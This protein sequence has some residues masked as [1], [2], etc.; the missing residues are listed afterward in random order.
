MAKKKYL[1]F[2]KKSDKKIRE[3]LYDQDY[4]HKLNEKDALLAI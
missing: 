4:I 3:E 1:G 2:S